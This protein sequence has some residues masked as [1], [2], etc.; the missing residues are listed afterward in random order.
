MKTP[1]TLTALALVVL[2]GA[3]CR[4]QP[5]AIETALAPEVVA[6]VAGRRITRAALEREVARR[7][8]GATKEAALAGLIQFEAV[9]AKARTAEFDR[10]P[11]IAAAI[12]RL[13]VARFEERELAA[14]ETPAVSESEVQARYAADLARYTVPAAARGGVLFL[15]SSPKAAADQRAQV[16][17]MAEQLHTQAQAAGAALFER[18]VREHSDDQASR[19]QRGDTGWLSVGQSVGWEPP[20]V[21]ALQALQQSGECAPLV[22]T[23]RGFY[24]VRLTETKP[25]STRPLAEVADSIRHQLQQ[26][27][28]EQLTAAFHARMKAGLDIRTNQAALEQILV[29]TRTGIHPPAVP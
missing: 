4:P 13:L 27:K 18:L 25:A 15:R 26:E 24:I 11:E 23:P 14:A 8:V 21:A 3:S 29:A 5:T 16:A 17:K 2:I 6:I 22:E 12:E 1:G 28:R 19:Y 20:V 10:D 9:L 7:G